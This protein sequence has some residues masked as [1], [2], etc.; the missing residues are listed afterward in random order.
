MRELFALKVTPKIRDPKEKTQEHVTVLIHQVRALI[1]LDIGT[2]IVFSNGEDL[3]V[4][5]SKSLLIDR[6]KTRGVIHEI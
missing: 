6:C 2:R 1:P 3:D 4:S 5:E